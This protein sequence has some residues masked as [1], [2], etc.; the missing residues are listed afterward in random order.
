[1]K[2]KESSEYE[3]QRDY[4]HWVEMCRNWHP[5]M[6][7]IHHIP[8]GNAY[9]VGHGQKL[10][11]MGLKPGI[12][13]VF[14]PWRRPNKHQGGYGGCYLEF[15]TLRGALSLAQKSIRPLLEEAGYRVEVVRSVSEAIN[16]TIDYL[17]LPKQ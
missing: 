17:N 2:L 13:D 4:F 5:A 8:N 11:K 1:M 14:I 7:L 15:K 12:P 3:I 9:S 16:V 6:A 10:K